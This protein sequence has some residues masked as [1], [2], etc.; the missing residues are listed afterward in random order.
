MSTKVCICG[1]EYG[2]HS[3]GKRGPCLVPVKP[4]VFCGCDYFTN[5]SPQPNTNTNTNTLAT[6]TAGSIT[7]SQIPPAKAR[8]LVPNPE[9]TTLDVADNWDDTVSDRTAPEGEDQ[10]TR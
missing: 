4:G 5:R 9:S 2:D 1:H 3:P 7:V 8:W 6:Y 10:P